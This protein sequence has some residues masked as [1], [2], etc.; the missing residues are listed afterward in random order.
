MAG[1]NDIVSGTLP[2]RLDP[3]VS[4]GNLACSALALIAQRGHTNLAGDEAGFE[5]HGLWASLS[6][7]ARRP[8]KARQTMPVS[9][10][11]ETPPRIQW[12]GIM[13]GSIE[14]DYQPQPIFTKHIE[15]P[16]FKYTSSR[17][18]RRAVDNYALKMGLLIRVGAVALFMAVA[19]VAYLFGL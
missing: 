17:L 4:C 7:A 13:T 3:D 9:P 8:V 12:S 19:S 2:E 18:E 1:S 11:S 16:T 15:R 10:G 14:V 5:A 6:A